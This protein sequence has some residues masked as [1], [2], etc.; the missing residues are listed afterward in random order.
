[1]NTNETEQR[2]Q[3]WRELRKDMDAAEVTIGLSPFAARMLS[4]LQ[5]LTKER[6][7]HPCGGFNTDDM[8]WRMGL[9]FTGDEIL[10]EALDELEK[11]KFI[12]FTGFDEE[13]AIE[14]C[15]EPN[16]AAQ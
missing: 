2:T 4:A 11:G 1:M 16:L 8:Q 9:A 10:H 15:Y 5:R 14:C 7:P 13:S 12:R 3:D 6:E